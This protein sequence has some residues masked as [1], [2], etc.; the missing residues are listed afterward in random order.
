MGMGWLCIRKREDFE[1]LLSDT[2]NR[3]ME[4]DDHLEYLEI[5]IFLVDVSKKH[6]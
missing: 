1:F 2:A 5:L 6:C 3:R 4:I